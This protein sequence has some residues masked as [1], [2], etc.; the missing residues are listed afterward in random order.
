MTV[1]ARAAEI[2]ATLERHLIERCGLPDGR[3]LEVNRPYLIRW[4][5][6]RL[7]AVP[8][9]IDR[10]AA[11]GNAV[12]PPLRKTN[13]PAPPVKKPVT[14]DASKEGQAGDRAV[15]VGW[16][17]NFYDPKLAAMLER[18]CSLRGYEEDETITFDT[19]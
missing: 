8:V 19:K 6:D 18:S 16:P 12:R 5:G 7:D 2:W 1:T 11:A 3:M 17:S 14:T 10:R 15:A 13:L 9:E 4:M